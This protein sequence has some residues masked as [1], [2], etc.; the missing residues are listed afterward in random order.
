MYS[1]SLR[2]ED[3]AASLI[4]HWTGWS[5][6]RSTVMLFPSTLGLSLI[7]FT[8]C[9]ARQK[10]NIYKKVNNFLVMIVCLRVAGG[11][12]V[13]ALDYGLKDPGFLQSH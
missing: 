6:R 9:P 8:T 5:V 13:K 11:L 7:R 3:I 1:Q 2:G 12:L 10:Y 4:P